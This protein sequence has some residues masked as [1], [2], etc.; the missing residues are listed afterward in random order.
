LSGTGSSGVAG[1]LEQ[2]FRVGPVGLVAVT[3][4]GDIAGVQQRD[5]V[6]EPTDLAAPVESRPARLDQDFGGLVRGGAPGLGSA[7]GAH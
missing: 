4:A 1:G 6:A 2:R 3:V 5:A 7:G